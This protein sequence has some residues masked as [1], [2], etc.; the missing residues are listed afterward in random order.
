[1]LDGGEGSDV[2]YGQLPATIS[3][4]AARATTCCPPSEGDDMLQGGDRHRSPCMAG[5]GGTIFRGEGGN[6]Q[7]DGETG[8]R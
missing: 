3:P 8:D 1:M 6:D 5:P 7:L 4:T 2:L